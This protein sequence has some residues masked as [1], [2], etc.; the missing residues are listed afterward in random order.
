[1]EFAEFFK[2]ATGKAPYPYQERLATAGAMPQLLDIPTGLGKTAAAIL[3]WLWRRRFAKEDTR[4]QTPRRL[5]YC[6]PMRVLVEQTHACAVSW[7]D[8]LGLLGGRRGVTPACPYDPWSGDDDPEKI[9]V[10][11]LMGGD[12]DRDWDMYPERDSIL[13]GTQDMLLS[14]ALNR[15]YAMSRFRWPVQFGLLNNDCL[16]VMDETQLMGVGIETS[17]QL[18]AFRHRAFGAHGP[19]YS[20]WMSATLGQRQL[21]TVDH[22]KP[23]SGWRIHKLVAD[24]YAKREVQQRVQAHKSVERLPFELSKGTEK[25]YAIDLAGAILKSH[26]PDSLTLIVVNRVDRAQEVYGQLLK[27]G[28]AAFNTALV[29]SRFR[30]PDRRGH[31]GILLGKG[32]RIVVATQAVEAGVDVS[33]KTLFAELAPW[34]SLV[35]RFG[36]C[37]RYGEFQESV[38]FW[39]DIQTEDEKDPLTLPYLHH[40]LQQA[41]S[42]LEK[43]SDAGP[44]DLP[45]LPER[46]LIRPVIRRKD[47]LDLFDTTPD[48]CGNDLDISRFIR[49]TQD[50]DVQVFWRDVEEDGPSEELPEPSRDEICSVSVGRFRDFMRKKKPGIWRWNP[51]EAHWESAPEARPGQTYLIVRH[52]GGY[53]DH[54]GWTGES[55]DIPILPAAASWKLPEAVDSDDATF[56]GKQVKLTKHLVHVVEQAEKLADSLRLEHNLRETLIAAARWHDVGKAHPVFQEMLRSTDAALSADMIWAK[57]ASNQGRSSRMGFRHELAS[58]LAWL[59]LAPPDVAQRNMVAYLVAAHHGRVRL[60]IRSWPNETE[61]PDPNILF[62]RGIWH[63]DELPAVNLGNGQVMT[64]VKLDLSVMRLGDGSQGESWLARMLRLRDD[65][66]IGPFRLALYETFLRIADWR[67]S[68]QEKETS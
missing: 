1:M 13:I 21:E 53:S 24:D 39:I 14:R 12:V 46:Q 8:N 9:R 19:T 44:Q 20:L 57:S 36:R 66:A 6:L 61:P 45:L 63:G 5:V 68:A 59:E 26:Q 47:L 29:H 49:D 3:A 18:D 58:A 41:R 62:A 25:S 51:L 40:D 15:G 64:T 23:D 16:W 54:L 37:N 56:I 65:P 7:L 32:D 34:A 11:L 48:L 55:T 27:L 43:L 2:R 38:V 17:A 10:H 60:S 22:P 52:S 50:T 30:A 42:A 28:R 4:R 33:A 67:A 31:E 35:Q